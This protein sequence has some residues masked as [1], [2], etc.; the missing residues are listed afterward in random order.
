MNI[1]FT[2]VQDIPENEESLNSQRI[3]VRNSLKSAIFAH[4][5]IRKSVPEGIQM[6]FNRNLQRTSTLGKPSHAYIYI[7]IYNVCGDD[8]M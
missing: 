6:K 4:S 1:E 5:A 7:Y 8:D 3:D 2:K